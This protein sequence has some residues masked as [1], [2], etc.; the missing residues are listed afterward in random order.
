MISTHI[1][2]GRGSSRKAKVGK[3]H[4]FYVS[5]IEDDLLATGTENRTRYLAGRL[6][7]NGLDSGSTD[8][9]VDGSVTEQLFDLHADDLYDIFITK[10]QI[11]MQDSV[12]V[13]HKF[14]N[15]IALLNGFTLRLTES[16][17]ATDLISSA[18]TG[19][20]LIQQTFQKVFFSYSF[21][22][23]TVEIFHFDIMDIL[24]MPFRIGRGT[25]DKI[26]AVVK[27]DLGSLTEFY[28]KIA[29]Y[30]KVA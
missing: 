27:D 29:G 24:G 23:E 25:K 7:K 6:G 1:T 22:G 30:K 14:G 18:K 5:I 3:K 19:G 16:G 13:Y 12:M 21:S 15:I 11:V 2:D 28:V 4:Q 9:N 10:V 8:M 20:E 26:E 17:V